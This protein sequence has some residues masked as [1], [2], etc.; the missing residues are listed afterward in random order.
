MIARGK[1]SILAPKKMNA[2]LVVHRKMIHTFTQGRGFQP[3]HLPS[4]K[5]GDFGFNSAKG[6]DRCL[7][8]QQRGR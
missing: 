3:G 2:S 1:L 5:S 4:R 8:V 6:G 7:M